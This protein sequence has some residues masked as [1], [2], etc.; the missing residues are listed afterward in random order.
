M[1]KIIRI[2]KFDVPPFDDQSGKSWKLWYRGFKY[3]LTTIAERNPNKLEVLFLYIGTNVSGIIDDCL[4]FNTAIQRYNVSNLP[5][6]KP[7][8]KSIL[9]IYYQLE[10]SKQKKIW[11]L[12]YKCSID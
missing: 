7:Q 2:E 3:F 6:L 1:D 8:A 5:T 12:S 11:M 10:R 9:V 4:D